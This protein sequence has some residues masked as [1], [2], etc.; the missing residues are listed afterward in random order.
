MEKKKGGD[1][2]ETSRK[3][4]SSKTNPRFLFIYNNATSKKLKKYSHNFFFLINFTA[5]VFKMKEYTVYIY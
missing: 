2:K 3:F 5:F 4:P 1:S